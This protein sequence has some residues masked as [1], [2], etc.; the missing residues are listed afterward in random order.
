MSHDKQLYIYVY[1]WVVYLH[2][3][4]N[5]EHSL[6]VFRMTRENCP[7]KGRYARMTE[8]ERTAMLVN[9]TVENR[10]KTNSTPQENYTSELTFHEVVIP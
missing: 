3:A 8:T 6:I 1:V 7:S 10:Q 9:D 2:T 4:R 5:R